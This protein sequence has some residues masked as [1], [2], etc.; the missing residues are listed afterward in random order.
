MKPRSSRGCLLYGV[1]LFFGIP[2]L[3]LIVGLAI[4]AG[5]ER[6]AKRKVA[7]RLDKITAQGLPVDDE[8]MLDFTNSLTSKVDTKEWLTVLGELT[9]KEFSKST[10]GVPLFDPAQSEEFEVPALGKRA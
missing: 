4:I 8:T 5:R 6:S 10:T 9:S 1:G 2:L 7:D 3:L